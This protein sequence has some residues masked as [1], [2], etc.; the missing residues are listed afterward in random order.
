MNNQ[1]CALAVLPAE[2]GDPDRLLRSL[3]AAK[4]AGLGDL[5]EI[6]LLQAAD[7]RSAREALHVAARSARDQG[8]VWLL[9][10]STAETLA[11]DIFVKTAPALRLH[12]AIWG[13]VGS[14]PTGKLERVTRLAAQDLPTFFHAALRWWI[15]PSHFVRP[16]AALEAL[17]SSVTPGW[18]A[19]YMLSLW[20]RC[21]AYKTA[22]CLTLFQDAVPPV[23]EVDRARLIQHLE[24]EPVFMKVRFGGAAFRLPY[25]G[26]NPVLE[27]EQMRGLFFEQEELEF[28][29]ERLP[30]GLRIV[31]V[32]ANT[33]NHTL[34]FA[35]VMAAE[36]VMPIEPHPRAVAA[37]RATVEANALA[38]VDLSCLGRAVGAG[39]GRLKAVNSASAGLG[40][41]HYLADPGGPVSLSPLDDLVAG[42]VDFIKIDVE[43]M[44]MEVLA[45]ARSTIAK[46]RPFIFIEVLD[47]AIE[48]FMA[49]LDKAGY[50]VEKL[51]PDK[52]HCNYFVAPAEK[53][54]ERARP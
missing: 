33:G 12:D 22:Q 1:R 24:R 32:G 11:P 47:T 6:V 10:V 8:F 14:A 50:R 37:I 2:E 23:E 53:A 49:W 44:E 43:G 48:S 45:G 46:Y 35:T 17:Q 7:G 34:F 5:A 30:R 21:R 28:L 18:Y 40:A 38:N 9:A 41:T 52:T 29:A 3:D 20:K 16:E 26:V 4:A 25:T 13:G 19:D 15:G 36:K 27:R 42:A 31:D 51:F 54:G 39:E